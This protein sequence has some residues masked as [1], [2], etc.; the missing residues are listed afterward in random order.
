MFISCILVSCTF[1]SI[2]NTKYENKNRIMN[3]SEEFTGVIISNPTKKE[4][5]TQYLLKLTKVKDKTV[6]I[7]VYL[8]VNENL[9]YGDKVSF[10]GEYD[11][12][13][14]ARNDKGF[15]YKNYLKSNRNCWR[16]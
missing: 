2:E 16:S 12:P 1:T 13:D 10:K 14:I 7:T 6:D 9:E 8:R 5:T 11:E 3:D 15:D 4:Y